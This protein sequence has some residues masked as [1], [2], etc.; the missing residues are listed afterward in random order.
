MNSPG[1]VAFLAIK[2]IIR[3]MTGKK[4]NAD[5]ARKKEAANTL[6]TAEDFPIIP[7][8]NVDLSKYRKVPLMGLAT[9]HFQLFPM[10]RGQS[11]EL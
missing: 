10:Q 2:D 4:E 11:Q 3:S 5:L 6:M 1:G 7:A 8:T 9:L